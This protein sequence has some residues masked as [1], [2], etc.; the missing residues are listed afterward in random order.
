MMSMPFFLF[1]AGLAAIGTGHRRIAIALWVA[2]VVATLAL[3]RLHAT[4][5]LNI[6]L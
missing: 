5:A 4:D 1:T 6:G 3:F 2:G